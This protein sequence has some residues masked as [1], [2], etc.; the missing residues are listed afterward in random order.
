MKNL[1]L[2]L[3]RLRR[4]STNT[5]LLFVENSLGNWYRK[6]TRYNVVLSIKILRHV[7]MYV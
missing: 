6:W 3:R 4:F 5:L 7:Q 2:A 1:V